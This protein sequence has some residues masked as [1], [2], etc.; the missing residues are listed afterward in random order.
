MRS[1]IGHS[2]F[3]TQRAKMEGSARVLRLICGSGL[4]S[5]CA[6]A[7]GLVSPAQHIALQFLRV[8]SLL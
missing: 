5:P 8:M 3:G 2:E 6:S 7:S 1:V 4:S